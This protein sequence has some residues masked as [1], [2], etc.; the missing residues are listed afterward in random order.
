MATHTHTLT[1]THSGTSGLKAMET[2]WRVCAW[3]E[4]VCVYEEV[5][6]MRP[7]LLLLNRGRRNVHIGMRSYSNDVVASAYSIEE[8]RLEDLKGKRKLFPP[9]RP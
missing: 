2:V 7:S 4:C 8:M 9:N 3:E 5:S 1:H 6:I